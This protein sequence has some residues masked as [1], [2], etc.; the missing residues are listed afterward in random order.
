MKTPNLKGLVQKA[1]KGLS[2]HSPEILMSIGIAGMV[3]T[4]VLTGK[5]SVKASKLIEEKKEELQVD[6]LTPVDTVKTTWKCFAPAVATGIA[7]TACLIGSHSVSA[8]RTAA[9]AT[10][11]K[12]SETALAEYKDAVIETIGEKKEEL[13]R[14]NV[15]KKQ[16]E[17]NPVA[18]KEVIVTNKGNTLCLD[19]L[20]GRYFRT[21]IDKVKATVNDINRRMVYDHYISLN[22]FY[23]EIGLEETRLGELLGW[24]LDDGL[25]ELDFSAQVTQY[26]EPCLV[27]NY[28][29]APSYDYY[30][31]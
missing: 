6:K 26:D 30:K 9:L 17:K 28:S 13:V 15:A 22:D 29:V 21:D 1:Q 8:R 23:A 27:L 10:A 31:F 2:K 4:A 20:S 11:Y 7:S 16:I 12:I 24:S 14:D 18:N 25:I 19:T 3:T 5:A